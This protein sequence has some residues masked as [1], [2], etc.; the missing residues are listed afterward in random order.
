MEL[1]KLSAKLK[2]Y[3]PPPLPERFDS[4]ALRGS[5]SF[6]TSNN[7][8]SVYSS[9]D[10]STREPT[11]SDV[12]AITKRLSIVEEFEQMSAPKGLFVV[13]APGTG[14]SMLIDMWYDTLQTKFR[15]R[16]HYN[17]LV[18]QIYRD[19]WTES[20]NRQR[21]LASQP[22]VLAQ[23]S[24]PWSRTL[25]ARWKAML[26]KKDSSTMSTRAP[27]AS[28]SPHF[29]PISFVV[30]QQML[31]K[32]WLLVFDEIQL[33]DI[34]SAGLLADVLAW[35]WRL[36]GVLVG[37][38]NK[39][40][41]E[42][43]RNGVQQDRLEP[44]VEALKIRSPVFSIRS[45]HDWRSDPSSDLSGSYWFLVEKGEISRSALCNLIYKDEGS[46]AALTPQIIPVFGRHLEVP[47]A[48]GTLC[49]YTF[50]QLC[51]QSLGSADYLAIASRFR[52]V[53]VT[54]IPRVRLAAKDQC[55]RFI[56]AIDAL[57]ETRCRL[58]CFAEVGILDLFSSEEITS[59]E[60]H[61]TDDII[62]YEGLSE[63]R[64]VNR[65][66]VSTYERP[67]SK[68]IEYSGVSSL[69]S[70]NS[71]SGQEERFAFKRALSRLV[72]MTSQSYHAQSRWRPL[73]QERRH[74][75][76]NLTTKPAPLTSRLQQ[77]ESKEVENS[78]FAQE[79]SYRQNGHAESRPS[80]PRFSENHIWGVREDWGPG[81]G[82]WG[83]GV[84]GKSDAPNKHDK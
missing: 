40:P 43:Y 25:K 5:P 12:H 83:R 42:L 30:A 57:Y 15:S 17:E 32:H 44:F 28:S 3:A 47:A 13:G 67:A 76:S 39:V 48:L 38:S 51:N 14:K 22:P 26:G 79:A 41:E 18:L 78:D 33:L 70:V 64:T 46:C 75:E 34:S 55:R 69:D 54:G 81:A 23:V 59:S 31:L 10:S 80:A 4:L 20:Q 62:M 1:R 19:V 68:E 66:N 84:A 11:I 8:N 71:F 50:E 16:K 29:L 72:E 52:T 58:V 2:D 65:P 63:M 35:Y 45:S 37:S 6:H 77:L 49:L 27:F 61:S 9:P 21:F 24:E 53:I 82:L 7:S 56:T 74:W 73:T 60:F 36:G